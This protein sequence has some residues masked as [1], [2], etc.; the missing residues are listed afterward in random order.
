MSKIAIGDRVHATHAASG[1]EATFTV[2]DA[3]I[4]GT[5]YYSAN[6]RYREVDGWSFE[7]IEPPKPSVTE[8]Y[9]AL[10]PGTRF[11]FTHAT[12]EYTKIDDRYF[13]MHYDEE[14]HLPPAIRDWTDYSY[15][16]AEIEVIS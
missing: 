11:S 13:V 4:Y 14:D 6:N 3:F 9:R 1:D 7:K 2:K 15:V 5:G 10:K 8:Q 12:V 16:A